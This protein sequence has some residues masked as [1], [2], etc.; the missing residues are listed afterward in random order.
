[1]ST[2]FNAN[3]THN[4]ALKGDVQFVPEKDTVTFGCG[5]LTDAVS[6]WCV[7]RSTTCYLNT[8]KETWTT[9]KHSEEARKSMASDGTRIKIDHLP[10]EKER[11]Y[12]V[13]RDNV[14][15]GTMVPDLLASSETGCASVHGAN[16]P[17][18]MRVSMFS[19][20]VNV[21]QTTAEPVKYLSS[22]VVMPAN[23]SGAPSHNSSC[24]ELHFKARNATQSRFR[25]RGE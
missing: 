22:P 16:R 6:T 14:G 13:V 4:N 21:T 1:M 12:Q 11:A 24:G 25:H 9:V 20:S 5:P 15:L 10:V 19:C 17:G 7:S 2:S 18:Q 3:I 8:K 23:A